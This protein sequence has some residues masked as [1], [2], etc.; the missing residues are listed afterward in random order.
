MYLTDI[1]KSIERILST[2]L[3]SRV[4][5]PTFGSELYLLIDR[6]LDD[7]WNLLFIKYVFEAIDTWEKRV[8]IQ[9]VNP[10]IVGEQVKYSLEFLIVNTNEIVKMERL[11]K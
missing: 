3:G 5:E 9:S 7:M 2:P 1:E 6:R 8:K 11:W 10:V 4:M